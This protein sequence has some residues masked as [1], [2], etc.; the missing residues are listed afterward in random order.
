[1]RGVIRLFVIDISSDA[2]ARASSVYGEKK[3]QERVERREEIAK[4][5]NE[6]G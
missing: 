2:S 5:S 6:K 3:R 4:W 1:M